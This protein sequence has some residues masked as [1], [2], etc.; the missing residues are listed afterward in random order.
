MPNR[1]TPYS[2]FS[3]AL[4]VNRFSGADTLF[5]GFSEVVGL[6]NSPVTFRAP[7]EFR[8]AG[9]QGGLVDAGQ[10]LH[11]IHKV[12][13]VTLKRGVVDSSSFWNWIAAARASAALGRS[14]G[15]IVL[16]NETG[17]PVQ[18]WKFSNAFPSHYSGPTLGGKGGNNIAIEELIISPEAI[19]IIPPK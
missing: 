4:Y 9:G 19:Q 15:T 13:D 8:R 3:Y 10:L 12:P 2:Q 11:G 18:R 17:Q 6:T 5:G 1:S 7:V 16:R 14:D